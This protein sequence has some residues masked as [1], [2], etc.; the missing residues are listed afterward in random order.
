MP[1]GKEIGAFSST[2][3]AL[4]MT[5]VDGPNRTI[6]GSFEGTTTGEV[7]GTLLRTITFSGD[8]EGG[9]YTGCGAAFT[10]GDTVHGEEQ[11]VYMRTGAGVWA[12]R[13]VVRLS[14]GQTI[15]LEGEVT[16]ATRVWDG[17]SFELK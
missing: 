12:T 5:A 7:A 3:T 15:V 8:D 14:T 17:K 11:G 1:L 10:A 16:L 6:E 2:A 4:R 9:S 13:G